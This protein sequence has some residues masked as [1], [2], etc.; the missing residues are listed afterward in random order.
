MTT[1]TKK[2]REDLSLL[3]PW[4]VAGTL[5]EA[6]TARIDAAL[7][8]DAA[9][10]GELELVLEDQVATRELI[11]RE[12]VPASMNARFQAAL[13]NAVSRNTAATVP[14]KQKATSLLNRIAG[15][16]APPRRLAFAAAAAAL[17]IVAQGGVILSLVSSAPDSGPGYVTA[18]GD[19]AGASDGLLVLVRFADGA[20]ATDVAT[21]LLAN[22]GR[23]VDGPLPGGLF[24]LRFPADAAA[25]SAA[26]A[27]AIGAQ[28]GI[29]AIV[30][31]GQ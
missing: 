26:L 31:P 22:G 1:L 14:E 11:E 25:D 28:K 9:L 15:F 10:R 2:E 17:L 8:R 3:L 19:A 29:F 5:D 23:V 18:S 21:W 27:A 6:Q 4:Y 16:L 13:E 24:K 20:G 30:L 12:D 7:E